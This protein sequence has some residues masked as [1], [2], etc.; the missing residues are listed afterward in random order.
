MTM[1][2]KSSFNKKIKRNKQGFGLIEAVTTAVFV[3]VAVILSLDSWFMITAARVTDAACR[4]AARA[5]AQASDS[6]TATRAANA[7]IQP[8]AQYANSM[9]TA[10]EVT[11]TY[12]DG[13]TPPSVTVVT[14]MSVTPLIPL[15][16]MGSTLNGM[17]F[18][19]QYT[20]PLIKVM[21][22]AN[23]TTIGNNT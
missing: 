9:M 13:A 22:N 10:P 5:A 23:S 14:R 19:Q 3:I 17:N 18:S 4:D 7:A 8:Y 21:T 1:V 12:N 16:C 15:S 6:L 11:V 2:M 20:F